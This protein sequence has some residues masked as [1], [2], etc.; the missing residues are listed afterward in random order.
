MRTINIT[1]FILL[2]FQLNAQLPSFPSNKIWNGLKIDTIANDISSIRIEY[3][4]VEEDSAFLREYWAVQKHIYRD[5]SIDSVHFVDQKN[6]SVYL[7]YFF[8]KKGRLK[9]QRRFNKE[10]W[11]PIIDYVYDDKNLSSSEVIYNRDSTL[12]TTTSIKYNGELLKIT[13]EAFNN[14]N[15]LTRSWR[16]EYD[17]CNNLVLE[18]YIN[19]PNGPGI[20]AFGGPKEPWPNDTT[21]YK[22]EYLQGC[23]KNTMTKFSNSHLINRTTYF[24]SGDTLIT[25]LAEYDFQGS[26][27][28]LIVKKKI[29]PLRIERSTFI[30]SS[31]KSSFEYVYD[32]DF[33]IKTS[34]E[35]KGELQSEE[36]FRKE[37]E[38]DGRGNWIVKKLY[39]NNNL[40]SITK[41]I[42]TYK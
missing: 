4:D 20:S 27:N 9:G 8:D 37:I 25:R 31:D 3:Y 13:R 19:T 22:I 18:L 38:I 16:Y 23:D 33:L 11:H 35:R 28:K 10:A 17:S 24:K 34:F 6:E 5:G 15:I 36:S 12:N 1:L 32:Q 21:M 30:G 2:S 7:S 26:E 29:D 40:Y 14:E 42:I 41:R 39:L